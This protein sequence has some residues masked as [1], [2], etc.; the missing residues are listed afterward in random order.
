MCL[1]IGIGWPDEGITTTRE[2]FAAPRADVPHDISSPAINWQ[3]SPHEII[4]LQKI[5]TDSAFGGI[6]QYTPSERPLVFGNALLNGLV[7]GFWQGQLYSI[8]LWADGQSGY[9]SLRKEVFGR[10]GP[11]KQSIT[12]PECFVWDG[13]DTQRMLKYATKQQTAIFTMR[14]T[15]VDAHI[16]QLYPSE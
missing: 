4:G 2:R 1:F 13:R 6:E 10:Y 3:M 14:S 8:V 9:N 7:F 5:K 15:L 11:G 12:D 16:K